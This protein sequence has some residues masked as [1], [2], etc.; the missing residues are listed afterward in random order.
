MGDIE[1]KF[2][3]GIKFVLQWEGGYVNHPDDPGGAT[4]KGVTQDTY[5]RYR[6]SQGLASQSVKLIS[7]EEV[8]YIYYERYF[9]ASNADDLPLKLS[10]AMFDWAVNGGPGRAIS[11]FQQ[12]V[13]AT[14]DG[15]FGPK[16][17]EAYKKK[18]VEIGD[19]MILTVFLAIREEYYNTR[20]LKLR[21]AFLKGWLNRLNSLEKYLEDL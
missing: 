12:A 13:G 18:Q 9:M 15:V 11:H 7:N 21:R 16:T 5:N 17:M 20:S 19:E 4:N 2:N 1:D 10:I 6:R 14:I 8:N 3:K